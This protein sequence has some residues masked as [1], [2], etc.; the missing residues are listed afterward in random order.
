MNDLDIEL[1]QVILKCRGEVKSQELPLAIMSNKSRTWSGR[2]CNYVQNYLRL[3]INFPCYKQADID[4]DICDIEGM[5]KNKGA[6]INYRIL[7]ISFL[8]SLCAVKNLLYPLLVILSLEFKDSESNIRQIDDDTYMTVCARNNC[9]Q[10]L[11]PST[12]KTLD[13]RHFPI[14]PVCY[15]RLNELFPPISFLGPFAMIFHAIIGYMALVLGVALPMS[16]LLHPSKC[17]AMMYLEA[18]EFIR[19]SLKTRIRVIQEDFKK[20]YQDYIKFIEERHIYRSSIN[21]H[22]LLSRLQP[23]TIQSAAGFQ[24]DCLRYVDKAIDMTSM[25]GGSAIGLSFVEET[26]YFPLIRSTWWRRRARPAF[27]KALALLSAATLV[28]IFV[29][30]SDLV[31]RIQAKAEESILI[32]GEMTRTNCALTIEVSPDDW[33]LVPISQ[34]LISWHPLQV[35]DYSM[36]IISIPMI[37]CLGAIFFL[38]DSELTCWRLELS[39]QLLFLIEITG[40]SSFDEPNL[41]K[42]EPN[43][44]RRSSTLPAGEMH[45]PRMRVIEPPEGDHRR[46]IYILDR[47][48]QMF[49]EDSYIGSNHS[50]TFAVE[51]YVIFPKISVHMDDLDD[52]VGL[53]Q[54]T[55]DIISKADI[56]LDVYLDLMQSAYISFRLLIEHVHHSSE[57]S[58]PISALMY[59]MT[60]GLIVIAVWHSKLM[61]QFNLEH[62]FIVMLSCL[63]SLAVIAV[64]SNFHS[65]VS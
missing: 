27:V 24:I 50:K 30:A 60:Y 59:V 53:Q 62:M 42:T 32:T 63:W 61:E 10:F 65:K 37:P 6:G 51:K 9:T 40:L 35:L 29:I 3:L 64:M 56:D 11:R 39:N 31:S 54:V 8:T 26:T 16:Q 52:K 43:F 48:R 49:F 15:P 36:L 41:C 57:A 55:L 20:S 45:E 19:D 18:P 12:G 7:S 17:D 38:I 22:H 23:G 5:K 46:F 21:G 58:A 13:V 4:Q 34:L 1:S 44:R 14:I 33:Q 2:I 47:I 28:E 25:R